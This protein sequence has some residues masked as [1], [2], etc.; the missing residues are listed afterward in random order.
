MG[1]IF[2]FSLGD[3]RNSMVKVYWVWGW[4]SFKVMT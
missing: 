3:V 1:E 4:S 2:G